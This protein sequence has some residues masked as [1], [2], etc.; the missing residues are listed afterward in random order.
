[1]SNN[2]EKYT[3]VENE[4]IYDYDGSFWIA[5]N[6]DLGKHN[7]LQWHLKRSFD[8]F[9]SLMGLIVLSPLFLV[10]AILVKLDS[11]GPVFY[12]QKRVGYLGKTFNMYKFRSMKINAEE[13]LEKLK[14]KNETNEGMFKLFDDPR[15]TRLGKLLRKYSIDE[16]PQLF[17]V[18]KGDMSLVGPRPPIISELSSYK[19]WHFVRFSSLPGITGVWQTSGRS[20]IKEFDKVV[21]L[22]FSYINNWNIFMD[23][24]LLFKTIPVVVLGKDTA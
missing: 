17:N 15:V 8:I 20:K 1:M 9:A 22:D 23:F 10:I 16:L 11:E 12:K 21:K 18:L 5:K 24:N 13:E 3:V 19:P 6:Y 14:S 2:K 4:T 7:S